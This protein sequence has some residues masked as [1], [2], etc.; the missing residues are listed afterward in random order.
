MYMVMLVLDDALQLDAVLEA[1]RAA[2]VSGVTLME[3]T[4]AYRRTQQP[5]RIAARYAIGLT[6]D[7]SAAYN[8]TLWIIVPDLEMAQRCLSEV[9]AVVGD[10]DGPNTGVL[11][12]WPLALVKGVP[13]PPRPADA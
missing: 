3:T 10:L 9:E 11:A 1:W 4:G 2:G 12:A 7:D 8:Y 6:P 5:Q 13:Q